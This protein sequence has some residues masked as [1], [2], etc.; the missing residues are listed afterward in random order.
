MITAFSFIEIEVC[1]MAQVNLLSPIGT[2]Y[3]VLEIF[4][5]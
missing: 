2:S 5:G 4:S 3:L 1:L